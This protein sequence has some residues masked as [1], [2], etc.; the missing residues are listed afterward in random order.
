MNC[1]ALFLFVTL[2]SSGLGRHWDSQEDE[3]GTTIRPRL[4]SAEGAASDAETHVGG[5][6]SDWLIGTTIPPR[7]L[8]SSEENSAEQH[9]GPPQPI[10]S[11]GSDEGES[12][13]L[14]PVKLDME[15]RRAPPPKLERSKIKAL[16]A[17]PSKPKLSL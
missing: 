7:H 16:E 9:N 11:R 5:H 1:G 8:A 2:I 14:A 6:D 12:D 15:K 3:M 17:M 13:F 4:N 10:N